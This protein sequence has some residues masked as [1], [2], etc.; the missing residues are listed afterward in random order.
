MP[1]ELGGSEFEGREP[2]VAELVK[3]FGEYLETFGLD[4]EVREAIVQLFRDG[5]AREG[6][7]FDALQIRDDHAADAH[8]LPEAPFS[9]PKERDDLLGV[10]ATVLE[11]I[12]YDSGQ[13]LVYLETHGL[14]TDFDADTSYQN[15]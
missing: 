8:D 13:F 10:A 4:E 2:E 1:E 3:V 14:I 9:E 11:E 7:Q 5:F 6:A 12:G 15:P